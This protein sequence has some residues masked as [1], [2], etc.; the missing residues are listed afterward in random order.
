MKVL[1]AVDNS[2]ASQRALAFA[3]RMLGD[4]PALDIEITLFHVV[5]SLPEFLLAAGAFKPAADQWAQ[6]RRQEGEK[7]LAAQRDALTKAG[8]PAKAVHTKLCCKEGRPESIRVVAA[9]AV[10]EEMQQGKY[11]VVVIGRRGA[12]ATIPT[13]LGGV[14]EKIAREAHGK[15]VWIVD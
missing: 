9:L 15:T 10:I 12:S 3:G 8:V 13:L 5:E 11:D 14:A 4:R 1:I 2:E 6:T 7:F